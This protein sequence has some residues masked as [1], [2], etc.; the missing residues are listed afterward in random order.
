MSNVKY[1]IAIWKKGKETS[2]LYNFMGDIDNAINFIISLDYEE[3]DEAHICDTNGN[4]IFRNS[5]R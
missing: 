2:D 4:I 5:M 3:I 1:I